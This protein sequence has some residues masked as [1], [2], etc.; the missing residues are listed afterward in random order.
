MGR[1]RLSI[2]YPFPLLYLY[3][4]VLLSGATA[5]AYEIVW[6]RRLSL[7]LGSTTGAAAAVLSSFMLGLAS[8]CDV[9]GHGQN[10][11][12]PTLLI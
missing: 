4:A 1:G 10:G 12:G 2:S 6:T 8:F 5:L 11:G 7:V 9:I 3:P